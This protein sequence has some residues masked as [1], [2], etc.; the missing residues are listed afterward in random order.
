MPA[1]LTLKL[2]LISWNYRCLEHIFI[3][4]K[5]FRPLKLHLPPRVTLPKKETN[6]SVCCGGWGGGTL[7]SWNYRCLEHIFIVTKVFRPLKLHLPPR[8]TLPKKETNLSVC[9]G[10]GGGGG[11]AT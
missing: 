3:V 4:T 6:L 9:C 2:T 7:I 5:V 8:V 10:G 1:D 11:G